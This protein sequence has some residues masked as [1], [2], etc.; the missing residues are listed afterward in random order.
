MVAF[1]QFKQYFEFSLEV[2]GVSGGI[3]TIF[4]KVNALQAIY[5]Y[6]RGTSEEGDE[7]V[8]MEAI[9]RGGGQAQQAAYHATGRLR[10]EGYVTEAARLDQLRAEAIV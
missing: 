5:K 3:A 1:D 6:V 7:A 9:Q 4:Y 10:E 8:A 2:A